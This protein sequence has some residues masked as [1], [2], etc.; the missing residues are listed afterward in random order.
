MISSTSRTALHSASHHTL[1]RSFEQTAV[2]IQLSDAPLC[3]PSFVSPA[4]FTLFSVQHPS[5]IRILCIFVLKFEHVQRKLLCLSQGSNC[6]GRCAPL[7]TADKTRRGFCWLFWGRNHI[8]S[9]HRVFSHESVC[10]C[11]REQVHMTRAAGHTAHS[12]DFSASFTLAS[13]LRFSQLC[14]HSRV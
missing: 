10:L 1:V 9:R 5:L 7:L 8:L 12:P 4:L 6:L 13:A 2:F 14:L 3:V 11:W